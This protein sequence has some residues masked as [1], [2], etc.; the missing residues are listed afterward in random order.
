MV[1][2]QKW[3]EYST[4]L[5]EVKNLFLSATLEDIAI[6]AGYGAIEDPTGNVLVQSL[7]CMNENM[8]PYNASLSCASDTT[9]QVLW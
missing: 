6:P 1:L 5:G 4:S 2:R 9:T 8:T 3:Q 7:L